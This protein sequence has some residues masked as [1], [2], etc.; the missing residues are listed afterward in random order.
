M[1]NKLNIDKLKGR[2]VEKKITH[3]K[4]A[5]HLSLS[6]VTVTNMLNGKA[7]I[8]AEQLYEISL[9]LNE[10]VEIFFN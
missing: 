5:E 4:L 9:L 3:Q 1:Q 10:K 2:L 7:K 6:R 8:S